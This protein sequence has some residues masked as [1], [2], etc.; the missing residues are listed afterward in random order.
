MSIT[1]WKDYSRQNG[2]NFEIGM[3]LSL[4]DWSGFSLESWCL[5]SWKLM[6]WKSYEIPT[7]TTVLIVNIRTSALYPSHP[8]IISAIFVRILH[9]GTSAFTPTVAIRTAVRIETNCYTDFGPNRYILL[10][11]LRNISHDVIRACRLAVG[12]ARSPISAFRGSAYCA[13]HLRFEKSPH[14]WM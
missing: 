1:S 2:I 12:I 4:V 10:C 8:H 5:L 14:H 7:T 3:L 11:E 9:V 13:Q 6:H